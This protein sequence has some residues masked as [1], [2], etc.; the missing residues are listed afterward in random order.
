MMLEILYVLLLS[1]LPSF[2]GR[3][4]LLVGISLGLTLPISFLISSL[5]VIALSLILPRALPL[6]DA[7]ARGL[8]DN[9]SPALSRLALLY[10]RYLDNA[11]R[12][13]S[14]YVYRYGFAGLLLFVAIPLPAT[15]VWT[16][17]IVAYLFGI[18]EKRSIPAL[19]SGGLLSN[20]IVS[21]LILTY[22]SMGPLGY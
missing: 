9:S 11:R 10:L 2:E 1:L 13:A 15:G 12:R 4:A 3:Y 18:G 7:V 17:A 19:L 21:L 16:G 6:V 20:V 14:K 8:A 22:S 5:G